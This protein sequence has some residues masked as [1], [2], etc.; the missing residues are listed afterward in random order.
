[1]DLCVENDTD[2]KIYVLVHYGNRREDFGVVGAGAGKTIGFGFGQTGQKISVEWTVEDMH[3]KKLNA[4]LP[5]PMP[6]KGEV[7]L[8]YQKDGTWTT[9]PPKK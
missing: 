4:A 6:T 9:A 5:M 8:T 2:K 7:T 1:M 3:G